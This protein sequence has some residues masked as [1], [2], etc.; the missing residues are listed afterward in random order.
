MKFQDLK[1]Y[2]VRL[3]VLLQPEAYTKAAWL[4]KHHV[5]HYIGKNVAYKS[6]LLPAEPFLVALHDKD[7][8]SVV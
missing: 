3:Y 5:F 6:T 4:R 1:R 7:R 2:V 8:K